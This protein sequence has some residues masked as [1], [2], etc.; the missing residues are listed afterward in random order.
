MVNW[1]Q[2]FS[3]TYNGRT[4]RYPGTLNV[5]NLFNFGWLTLDDSVLHYNKLVDGMHR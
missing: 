2:D 5:L 4:G 3:N 1:I